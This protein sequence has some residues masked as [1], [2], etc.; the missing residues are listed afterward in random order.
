[1]LNADRLGRV[2][3]QKAGRRALG[4][5]RLFHQPRVLRGLGASLTAIH[6]QPPVPNMIH[7]KIEL[8]LPG[9][10]RRRQHTSPLLEEA[11]HLGRRITDVRLVVGREEGRLVKQ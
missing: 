2:T 7:T 9:R 4:P 5:G 11:P 3:A 10:P 1:M 8:R 6:F